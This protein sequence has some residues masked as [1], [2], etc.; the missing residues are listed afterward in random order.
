M[1]TRPLRRARPASATCQRPAVSMRAPVALTA[2]VVNAYTSPAPACGK[3][4]KSAA[5]APPPS[6]YAPAGHATHAVVPGGR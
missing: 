3:R 2:W 6:A 4:E 1:L 5:R